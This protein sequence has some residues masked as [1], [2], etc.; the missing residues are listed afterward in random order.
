MCCL[1]EQRQAD[2]ETESG[3]FLYYDVSS[4]KRYHGSISPVT[5]LQS[6]K[7]RCAHICNAELFVSLVYVAVY[8]ELYPAEKPARD[9]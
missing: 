3:R 7:E 6:L 5:T 9:T 4:V 1:E 2:G 8:M